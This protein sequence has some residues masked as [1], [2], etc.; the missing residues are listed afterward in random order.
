MHTSHN[1]PQSLLRCTA[2]QQ[3]AS[4]FITLLVTVYLVLPLKSI[5]STVNLKDTNQLK[6]E[7]SIIFPIS[8]TTVRYPTFSVHSRCTQC[9]TSSSCLVRS[10]RYSGA[11]GSTCTSFPCVLPVCIFCQLFTKTVD[12][13]RRNAFGKIIPQLYTTLNGIRRASSYPSQTYPQPKQFVYSLRVTYS[14]TP[15]ISILQMYLQIY[16]V[17]KLRVLPGTLLQ[18]SF[19][20][21]KYS[22]E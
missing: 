11:S 7:A 18:S 16:E 6:E 8:S 19:Y 15:H 22:Y 10:H 1:C 14:N 9:K 5:L 4:T 21:Y 20:K 13:K 3:Q 17:I 12:R 2:K